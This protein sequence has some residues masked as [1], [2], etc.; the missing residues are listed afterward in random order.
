MDW[1]RIFNK[2]TRIYMSLIYN[3]FFYGLGHPLLIWISLV[4]A[5]TSNYTHHKKWDEIIYPFWSINGETV[6]VSEWISDFIP[7]F[8]DHFSML[9]LKLIHVSERGLCCRL[10]GSS[11]VIQ[12]DTKYQR[13]IGKTVDWWPLCCLVIYF[14]TKYPRPNRKA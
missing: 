2:I 4:L 13:P 7:H 9:G 5:W 1:I 12:F 8:A 10:D 11:L 14:E 6:Y 3:D